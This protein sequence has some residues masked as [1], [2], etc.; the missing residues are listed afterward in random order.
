M[1]IFSKSPKPVSTGDDSTPEEKADQKLKFAT[2]SA[3]FGPVGRRDKTWQEQ[4]K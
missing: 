4:S 3:R 2:A 1:G